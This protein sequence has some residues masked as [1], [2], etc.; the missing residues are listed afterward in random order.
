MSQVGITQRTLPPTEFGEVRTA[1]DVRWP[2]FLARCGLVGVPLPN[3][4][5]LAINA[6]ESLGLK[7]IIFTGGDD[8]VRY[9]GTTPDRDATEHTLLVWAL[10]AGWPVLGV[11][12]GMQLLVDHFGGPLA[13]VDGHV[14]NTHEVVAEGGT[15]TVTCYHRWAA[16]DVPPQLTVTARRGDVVEAVRTEDGLVRGIM[17]HPERDAEPDH[18]DISLF[19]DLFGG[20]Q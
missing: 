14:A 4:P 12:R 20:K 13:G 9:G 6:M 19:A 16:L 8:L 10:R 5:Q 3:D 17:W 7:G 18:R 15:R 2:R 11:C 1:L